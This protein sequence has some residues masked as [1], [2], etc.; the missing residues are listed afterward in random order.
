MWMRLALL[1]TL[2]ALGIS[3]FVALL[4]VPAVLALPSP[5]PA[6]AISPATAIIKNLRIRPFLPFVPVLTGRNLNQR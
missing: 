2:S 5:A 4:T 1:L 6:S 3:A